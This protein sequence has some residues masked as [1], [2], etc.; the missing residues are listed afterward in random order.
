MCQIILPKIDLIISFIGCLFLA[1]S[2]GKN[3]DEAKNDEGIYLVS[4]LH[5]S[6]FRIGIILI[7]S[8]FIL[9]IFDEEFVAQ[10]VQSIYEP[11]Y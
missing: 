7:V 11:Q 8:G 10:I 1:Y 9:A 6:F 3:P 4:F 2:I 5:P